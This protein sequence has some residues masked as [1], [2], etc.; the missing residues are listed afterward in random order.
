ML[1]LKNQEENLYQIQS[2]FY[3]IHSYKNTKWFWCKKCKRIARLNVKGICPN[4]FN[5]G[6][7]EE[8]DPNVVFENNYYRY[9]YINKKIEKL[10]Y[11]EHTAQIGNSAGREHYNKIHAIV[12]EQQM[13]T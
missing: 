9:Q 11:K 7:L 10:V 6:Y 4:C 5:K 2:V 13:L 12:H 1:I 3:D 8:A